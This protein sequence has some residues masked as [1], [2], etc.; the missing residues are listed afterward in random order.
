M[1]R[2]CFVCGNIYPLLASRPDIPIVGGAEVQVYLIARGLAQAGFQVSFVSEDFGQGAE[3]TVGDYRVLGYRLS[4]N[5]LL[6]ARTLWQALRRADAEIY[7]VQGLPK[8][9]SLIYLFARRHHRKLVQALFHDRE[10]EPRMI[11][12]LADRLIYEANFLWR[13]RADLVIAQTHFQAEQL[14][15]RW[16]I[17]AATLP[18]LVSV[19]PAQAAPQQFS[20]LWVANIRPHKQVERVAEIADQLP[21]VNFVVVGGPMRGMEAY[22]E[23]ARAQVARRA[24]VHWM[25][26]VP[27]AE[28]GRLFEAASVLLHTSTQEGF[29]NVFLQAWAAGMPVVSLGVDP[30]GLIAQH[31][32]GMFVDPAE[33]AEAIARLHADPGL[34][35]D[36]GR[37]ARAYVSEVHRPEVVLPLYAAQFRSLVADGASR[38]ALSHG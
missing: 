30:D 19:P 20:V 16:G 2:V 6:Q 12:H 36:I 31:G 18:S 15:L 21:Q 25:G 28:I 17:A 34:L 14:R 3:T 32:L 8:F 37:R 4:K 11:Q 29:P 13:S 23:Q 7:Y 22:Y 10:V 24:N 1:T 38:A 5:K 27:Y 26:F 33:G 35:Q 9:S